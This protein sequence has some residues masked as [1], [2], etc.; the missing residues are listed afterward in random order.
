M[1]KIANTCIDINK[2]V[3]PTQQSLANRADLAHYAGQV[4][5]IQGITGNVPEYAMVF[6][7]GLSCSSLWAVKHL[8]NT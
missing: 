1:K 7:K 6:W 2:P 3:T 8:R 4:G 5:I